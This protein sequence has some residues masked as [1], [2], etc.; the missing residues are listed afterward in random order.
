MALTDPAGKTFFKK[1]AYGD[2][3]KD[4]SAKGAAAA[5]KGPTQAEIRQAT[6]EG[7]AQAGAVSQAGAMEAA[8]NLM[9][10]GTVSEQKN[11]PYLF[12]ELNSWQKRKPRRRR[13]KLQRRSMRLT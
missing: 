12:E 5:A 10:A 3:I 1:K 13:R 6:A 2:E 9:G 4:I 11:P 7:A 8:Q